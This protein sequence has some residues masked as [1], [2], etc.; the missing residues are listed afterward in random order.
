MFTR[1]AQLESIELVGRAIDKLSVVKLEV[2]QC[3]V[4]QTS[5]R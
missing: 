3:L 2:N 5:F 4:R 1:H